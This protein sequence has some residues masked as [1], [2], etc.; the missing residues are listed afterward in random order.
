[1]CDATMRI[2]AHSAGLKVGRTTYQLESL[3]LSH[4]FASG[5]TITVCSALFLMFKFH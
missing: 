4:L 1:M 5:A 3:V 2:K